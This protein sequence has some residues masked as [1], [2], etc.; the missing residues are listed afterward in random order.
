ME[1]AEGS[2][3]FPPEDGPNLAEPLERINAA[4]G[5]ILAP[6]SPKRERGARRMIHECTAACLRAI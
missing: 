4:T 5:S 1:R 2:F 6:V 3:A